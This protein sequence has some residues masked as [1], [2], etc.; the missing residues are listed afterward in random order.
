MKVQQ[1]QPK[2]QV[3]N[4]QQDN[5]N[6]RVYIK[7]ASVHF[8]FDGASSE[9]MYDPDSTTCIM[10]NSDNTLICKERT[11]IIGEIIPLPHESAGVGILGNQSFIQVMLE[12]FSGHGWM[13]KGSGTH[14]NSSMCFASQTP[15]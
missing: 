2:Q 6:P 3:I 7:I 4:G 1:E 14:Y 8:S 15:L 11:H 12:Q 10:D 13:I 9:Q 5:P